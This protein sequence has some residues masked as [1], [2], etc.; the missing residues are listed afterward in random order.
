M[1]RICAWCN[2]YM[3]GDPKSTIIT[4]GICEDCAEK[5]L[6]EGEELEEEENTNKADNG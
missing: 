4:H 6:E 5:M 2:K 1:K 3:G